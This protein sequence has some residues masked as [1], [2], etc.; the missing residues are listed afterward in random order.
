MPNRDDNMVRKGNDPWQIGRGVRMHKVLRFI[1]QCKKCE[2]RE[3]RGHFSYQ[4]TKDGVF[5]SWDPETTEKYIYELQEAGFVLI[6]DDETVIY[7]GEGQDKL[8]FHKSTD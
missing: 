3:I 8:E 4:K 7:V 1:K 2:I 5:V 6:I